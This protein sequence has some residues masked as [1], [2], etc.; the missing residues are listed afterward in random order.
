ME[1]EIKQLVRMIMN[2]GPG[3]GNHN[4]GQGRGVGK[5]A[6]GVSSKVAKAIAKGIKSYD[7]SNNID[8]GFTVNLK[9]GKSYELGK[10]GGF[11]VGG[12][13]PE[14]I[15]EKETYENPKK[16][17]E[18]IKKYTKQNK[19]VFEDK[20]ICLGGW[21][22][23]EGELKGKLVLDASRVLKSEREA[24]IEMVKTDQ[25]SI[26]DFKNSSWP[27]QDELVD[28]YNLQ[29]LQAKYKGLRQKERNS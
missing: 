6:S 20:D 5:P 27:T 9:T 26:T 28:K 23:S 22:P 25:D 18:E 7:P 17:N 14:K 21:I 2:G 24:A 12:Y 8:G 3:S 4:P 15:L 13:A 29:D 16:L 1:R 10:T 19:D 11:A